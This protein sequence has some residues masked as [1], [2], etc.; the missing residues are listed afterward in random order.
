MNDIVEYV[1]KNGNEG[2]KQFRKEHS[3]SYTV[4]EIFN[5]SDKMG[6]SYLTWAENCFKDNQNIQERVI[7]MLSEKS[8]DIALNLAAKSIRIEA[9]IPGKSA[10]GIEYVSQ[11]YFRA[12]RKNFAYSRN[13]HLPS[14]SCL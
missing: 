11:Q 3:N 10:V 7:M 1:N 5:N 8:L 4:A 9:P 14:V 2:F 12:H 13:L 6:T